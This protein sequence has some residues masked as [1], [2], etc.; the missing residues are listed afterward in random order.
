MEGTKELFK[1]YIGSRFPDKDLSQLTSD[2]ESVLYPYIK[3]QYGDFYE[4]PYLLSYE[5][6]QLAIPS[7]DPFSASDAVLRGLALHLSDF[8]QY[9]MQLDAD[10]PLPQPVRPTAGPVSGKEETDD[11]KPEKIPVRIR[12]PFTGDYEEGRAHTQEVTRYE[13]NPKARKRCIEIYGCKCYICG[14]DFADKYGEEGEG[15]IEVHHLVRVADKGGTYKPDPEIDLRPL[16]SNCHS[17]VHHAHW[18]KDMVE[19]M[20]KKHHK[21]LQTD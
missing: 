6:L 9:L 11:K 13:R 2:I 8:Q 4:S 16:C 14:F 1:E 12:K 5:L 15:F 3:N 20:R 19:Q 10:K 21:D 7:F 17:M 18:D